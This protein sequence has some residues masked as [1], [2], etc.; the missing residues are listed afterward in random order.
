MNTELKN[1][2]SLERDIVNAIR[3]RGLKESMEQWEQ[4]ALG[5]N[6]QENTQEPSQPEVI[7]LPPKRAKYIW[8]TMGIAA[9]LLLVVTLT[10]P[11][12]TWQ[13][14]YHYGQRQYA[15]YILHRGSTPKVSTMPDGQFFALA[16]P[17]VNDMETRYQNLAPAGVNS[18][19]FEAIVEMQ[20]S[21][22]DS[23]LLTLQDLDDN[24]ISSDD[25]QLLEAIC[26]AHLGHRRD[27]KKLL[28]NLIESESKHAE[29][30]RQLISQYK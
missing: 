1:N 7:K 24:T 15:K 4:A 26:H 19:M 10:I 20:G 27:A 3:A 13:Q 23:A 11:Q 12:S 16:E 8:S 30:A 29:L 21:Q 18:L 14:V 5:E 17:V 2:D 25:I 28:N 6:T 9:S 22:Y